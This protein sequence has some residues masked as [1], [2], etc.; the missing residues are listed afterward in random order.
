MKACKYLDYMPHFTQ[1]TL[2]ILNDFN[3]P[4]KYWHRDFVVND[5]CPL[6]VQF[7]KLRGRINSIFACYNQGEMS[8]YE[9]E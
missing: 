4:V 9:P 2:K 5:D 7:C 8:C 6:D 3:P 1:C